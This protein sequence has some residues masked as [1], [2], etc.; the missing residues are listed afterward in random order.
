MIAEIV[1]ALIGFQ[2]LI[3]VVIMIYNI[4]VNKWVNVILGLLLMLVTG[5][6]MNIIS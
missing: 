1:R 5:V 3:G 2:L 4:C 6:L